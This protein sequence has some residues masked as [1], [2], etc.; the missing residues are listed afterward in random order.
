MDSWLAAITSAAQAMSEWEAIAVI[1]SIAYLVLAARAH[2]SCWYCALASTAIFSVLFWDV[3]LL[4]DSGLNIYYMVMAVYGWHQWRRGGNDQ[5]GVLISTLS[6]KQHGII[7]GAIITLSACSG[8]LLAANTTAAWPYLD[9]FTTWAGV[10]TT[11]MVAHKVLEN[12]IYWFVVDLISIPLYIERGLHL[13]ALMFVIYLLIVIVGFI[14]W[15]KEYAAQ[16]QS[17]A[18]V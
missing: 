8:Y 1:L 14:R 3:S 7:V 15:R 10:I 16:A 6:T 9:S 2:I 13:T 18:H 5:H 17:E 11:V 4:M 12:W